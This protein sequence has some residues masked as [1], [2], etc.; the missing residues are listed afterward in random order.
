MRWAVSL[1]AGLAVTFVLLMFGVQSFNSF[2]ADDDERKTYPLEILSSSDRIDLARQLG[3]DIGRKRPELPK[4]EDLPQLRV[5][6]RVSTGFVQL[7]VS[8]EADGRVR[9]AVVVGA[10][11]PQEQVERVRAEIL[12]RRFEPSIVDGR[13]IPSVRTEIVDVTWTAGD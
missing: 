7:E 1:L 11:A 4:L 5:P 6:K 3:E 10:T 8:V 12:E 2:R 13:P 9:E